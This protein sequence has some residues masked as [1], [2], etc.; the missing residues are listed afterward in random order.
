MTQS[1]RPV[2]E[3]DLQAWVDGFLSPERLRTVET[4][5]ESHPDARRR[6]TAWRMERDALRMGLDQELGEAVPARFDL[7]RLK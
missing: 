6:V 5:L 1:D 3:D 2:T 4:W 7:S